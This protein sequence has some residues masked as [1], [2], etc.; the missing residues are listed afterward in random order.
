[1]GRLVGDRR[2]ADALAGGHRDHRR[3]RE[4]DGAPG[5]GAR[6]AAHVRL[7]GRAGLA[8]GGARVRAPRSSAGARLRLR[9]ALPVYARDGLPTARAPHPARAL[10][11]GTLLGSGERAMARWEFKLPDV[12]EGVTEGEIVGW[13]IK[14]GDLVKEDQPMVEVM[15]DKAT[16]TIT[17][18]KGGT[19]VETRGK[20]GEI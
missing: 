3:E 10:G 1:A 18:P 15:T 8:G 16:V 7:R 4:E 13:L 6:G 14:P 12:G 2:S 9:Y 17:A 19:V 5:G 11:D 20:V